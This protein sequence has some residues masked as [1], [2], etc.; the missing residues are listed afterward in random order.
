MPVARYDGVADWYDEY[1]AG[2]MRE[3]AELAESLARSLLSHGVGAVLDL[4]C[5]TGRHRE[6]LSAAG[7]DVIGVDLSTD[8]L[9]RAH[10]RH[11]TCVQADASRL[12]FA[13]ASFRATATIMTATDFD[14]L[15][16]V[17]AEARRVTVNDGHLVLVM[18]HPCFGQVFEEGHQDGSVT[19]FPG[20]RDHRWVED[21]PL[22]GDGIRR[23]VGTMNVPLPALLNS[24]CDA[25]WQLERTEEDART[26][27]VPLLLGIR[28]RAV[29]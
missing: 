29:V 24:L 4:G 25:G 6:A 20:Y 5:G 27:A 19:V 22:L 15:A 21:H 1:L 11:E 8:Q 2:Q 16:S 28:A 9:R 17:L 7:Y 18:A 13:A 14:N 12:P 23:R 26:A 10:A 3:V